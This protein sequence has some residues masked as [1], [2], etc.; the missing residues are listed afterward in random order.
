MPVLS[1]NE[2]QQVDPAGNLTDAFEIV[3]TVTGRT[4][5][6]TVTVPKAGD[7]VAAAKAAIDALSGDVSAIYGL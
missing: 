4:G 2:T 6:F 5:S 3:F 7:P 1:V